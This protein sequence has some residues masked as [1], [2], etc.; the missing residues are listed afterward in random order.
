VLRQVRLLATLECTNPIH[1]RLLDVRLPLAAT[2]LM[3][4]KNVSQANIN[5][6]HISGGSWRRQIVVVGGEK[7]AIIEPVSG[8]VLKA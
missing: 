6:L 7:K 8:P 5:L 2:E 1:P 4:S 3:A